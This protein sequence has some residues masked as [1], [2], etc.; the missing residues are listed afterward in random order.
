MTAPQ[1]ARAWR[2]SRRCDS[3][4]CVEVA[5]VPGGFAVR[6]STQP[7]AVL[8]FPAAQWKTF[9]AGVRNGDFDRI[10]GC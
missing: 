7:D 8:S 2:R 9:V 5:Q 3:S 6:D 10:D 4:A 1:P